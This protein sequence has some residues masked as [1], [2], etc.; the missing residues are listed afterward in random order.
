[1]L[2]REEC[3]DDECG[4][5]LGAHAPSIVLLG[6]PFEILY[7]TSL[8]ELSRNA[9]L[10]HAPRTSVPLSEPAG[11]EVRAVDVLLVV[12][13]ADGQRFPMQARW[14]E[15]VVTMRSAGV[16]VETIDGTNGHLVSQ[17]SICST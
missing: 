14:Q 5:S 15:A 4:T 16:K 7:T 11:S 12:K 10:V 9:L 8:H 1:V 2:R 6:S 17:V 13:P 3:V